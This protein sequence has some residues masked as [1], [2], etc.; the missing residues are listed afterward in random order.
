MVRWK[1][2]LNKSHTIQCKP[3]V[4]KW[5]SKWLNFEC[6]CTPQIRQTTL[7]S[8]SQ[9]SCTSS[10]YVSS[11]NTKKRNMYHIKWIRIV[12]FQPL[13][14]FCRNNL[15]KQQFRAWNRDHI[16][17]AMTLKHRSGYWGPDES[18]RGRITLNP[19]L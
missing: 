4:Y 11:K 12:K 1:K 15:S 6:C 9:A 2:I 3:C 16:V 5:I 7:A 17:I 14:L 13:C 10:T 19:F 8:L 18:Y